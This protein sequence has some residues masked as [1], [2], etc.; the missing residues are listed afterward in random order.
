MVKKIKVSPISDDTCYS[1]VVDAVAENEAAV[2][3]AVEAVEQPIEQT[4]EP[5][6]E[7]TEPVVETQTKPKKE[8]AKGTCENCGKT[9]TLKN[10]RYSHSLIC[11]AKPVNSESETVEP[12]PEKPKLVRS[13]TV[14]PEPEEVKPEEVKPVEVKPKEVKPKVKKIKVQ[15]EFEN[16]VVQKKSKAVLKA[17]KYDALVKNAL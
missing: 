2:E 5:V 8:A 12:I 9:M 6:M 17:E 13:V 14:H 10:L 4:P 7:T 15:N 16:P 3:P 11:K 1:E